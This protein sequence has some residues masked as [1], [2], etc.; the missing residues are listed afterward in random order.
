MRVLQIDFNI[1]IEKYL[2][3]NLHVFHIAVCFVNSEGNGIEGR[4]KEIIVKIT[5]LT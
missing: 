3:N 4:K 1:Y 2:N 5:A